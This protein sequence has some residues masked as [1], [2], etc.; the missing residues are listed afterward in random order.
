ME[1][2][3]AA[4]R[5]RLRGLRDAA[6]GGE[7]ASAAVAARLRGLPEL[8]AAGTVL[9]YA[10]MPS[11]VSV[12]G[13][14]R[15]LL[16]RGT[17]VCLPWVE[18]D[19]LAVGAVADLDAD[20]VAG[21]HGLREPARQRRTAA[22]P[23]A[24]D[25]L[26]VPGLGFDPHGNRLGHGGGHFDRLLA[27]VRADALVAGVALDAQVVDALPVEPHDRRVD[28]VVTPTRTLRAHPR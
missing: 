15:W 4:L 3:K 5:R 8:A 7:A 11:E 25:V 22:A 13:V 17:V 1:E 12:D 27:Q 10:A 14:L 24:L 20:L 23:Q 19:A 28:L 26:L 21:W 9:G 18:G 6:G 2:H 16:A